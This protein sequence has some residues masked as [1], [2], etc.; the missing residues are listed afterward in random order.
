MLRKPATKKPS[1]PKNAAKAKA[2]YLN[3]TLQQAELKQT[4][5]FLKSRTQEV[6]REINESRNRLNI[7]RDL[8]QPSHSN[9]L[10][11]R[12][13][14]EIGNEEIV[15]RNKPSHN[16]RHSDTTSHRYPDKNETSYNRHDAERQGMLR[17]LRK[18]AIFIKL[19]HESSS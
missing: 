19:L 15:G 6:D 17:R 9:M 13:T 1:M 7:S 3:A 8:V 12:T 4:Q 11:T 16:S 14:P 10:F 2:N 5:E 18:G